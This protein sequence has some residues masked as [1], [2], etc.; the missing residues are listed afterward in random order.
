MVTVLA[1]YAL[2]VAYDNIVDYGSNYEFVR[3][4]LTMDTTFDAS[5]LK[6]R[7]ISNETMWRVAYALIIGVE[8]RQDFY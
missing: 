8:G 2:I 6:Y 7:A 4:V 1:V 5:T 3:H